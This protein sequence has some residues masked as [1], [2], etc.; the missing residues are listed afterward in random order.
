MKK[1]KTTNCI[2]QLELNPKNQQ[3]QKSNTNL[4]REK[5]FIGLIQKENEINLIMENSEN[6]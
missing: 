2:G 3:K 4:M 5:T 6:S 1:S